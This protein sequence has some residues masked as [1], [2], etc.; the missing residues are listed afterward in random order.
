MTILKRRKVALGRFTS[1]NITDPDPVEKLKEDIIAHLQRIPKEIRA[2]IR[3]NLEGK[4]FLDKVSF[5]QQVS[6]AFLF[7]GLI[8][9]LAKVK[10]E[11]RKGPAKILAEVVEAEIDELDLKV[12]QNINYV[13]YEDVQRI[14][15]CYELSL[16]SDLSAFISIEKIQKL[17]CMLEHCLDNLKERCNFALCCIREN[18][19]YG[20]KSSAIHMAAAPNPLRRN[21]CEVVHLFLTQ[22]QSSDIPIAMRHYRKNDSNTHKVIEFALELFP[23]VYRFLMEKWQRE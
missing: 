5:L 17:K 7:E 2:L 4:S 19:I 21:P 12:G 20:N 1:R 3:K 18:K 15:K 9:E 6:D 13:T 16:S 23:D 10:T 11:V 14:V 22:P 8:S